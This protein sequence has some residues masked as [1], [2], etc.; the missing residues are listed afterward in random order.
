[1]LASV[2]AE[3]PVKEGG[4]DYSYGSSSSVFDPL[5][6]GPLSLG[7]SFLFSD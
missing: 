3:M 4:I 1:M 6:Q 2:A 7:P 5:S